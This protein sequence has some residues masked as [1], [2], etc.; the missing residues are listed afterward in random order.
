MP[1]P[2]S[3]VQ[4][5]RFIC[6][7]AP[8]ARPTSFGSESDKRYSLPLTFTIPSM[9]I[10]QQAT[11]YQIAR[12]VRDEGVSPRAGA[13]QMQREIGLNITSAS[14]VIYVYLHMSR[15]VQYKRALNASD[16]EYLLERI[17]ADD[18]R[19]RLR[20]A[21]Q[22]FSL[23]IEYREGMRV[24]QAANRAILRR[25][26]LWLQQLVSQPN[27]EPIDINELNQQF[28]DQVQKSQRDSADARQRRLRSAP[29]QPQRVA[30]TVKLF[31]RNPDVVAEVLFRANGICGGCLKEAPFSR[32]SDASP[33]LEVHHRTPLAEYGDDTVTNAIALCPNC[34]RSRHFGPTEAI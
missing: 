15:G 26:E 6:R 13:E 21:L 19:Q 17:G 12:S 16:T 34:H 31:Q 29:K 30:K 33:Y 4:S 11:A 3:A 23:H 1:T 7:H 5:N 24:S 20:L 27:T 25:Q 28:A 18:G 2:G 14:F 8:L 9:N 32:R 10:E 22:A